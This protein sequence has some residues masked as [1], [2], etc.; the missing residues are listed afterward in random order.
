MT[1]SAMLFHAIIDVALA[2]CLVVLLV[3]WI[4]GMRR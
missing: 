1:R 2:L 3:E 4:R